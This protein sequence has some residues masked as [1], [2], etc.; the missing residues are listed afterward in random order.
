MN[1][2]CKRAWVRHLA[3]KEAKQNG[4]RGKDFDIFIRDGWKCWICG[5]LCSK[6][7]S[8]RDN[9]AA[10]MDHIIPISKGG[11]HVSSN[12]KTAC[13][14]CNALRGNRKEVQLRL[15]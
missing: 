8:N 2:K 5:I 10:T 3:E 7:R 15:F 4:Y 11:K 13:R 1:W 14:W 12:I 6:T 9:K